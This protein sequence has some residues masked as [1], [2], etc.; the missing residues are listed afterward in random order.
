M[1]NLSGERKISFEWDRTWVG[2]TAGIILP[3]FGFY[4]YYQ[5]VFG[6]HMSLMKFT[7]FVSSP[8]LLSKVMSLSVLVNLPLFFLF[9]RKHFDFAARGAL[10]ATF[11]Y[12]GIIAIL[13]F[14]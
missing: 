2:F 5:L 6:D 11:V 10:M 14:L 3:F 1:N 7:R 8:G 4:F 12:A 9:I 13:K